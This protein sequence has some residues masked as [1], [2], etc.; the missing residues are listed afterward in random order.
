[1][2]VPIA[3][4]TGT[5][6]GRVQPEPDPVSRADEGRN[7]LGCQTYIA[8]SPS[9]ISEFASSLISLSMIREGSP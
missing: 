6:T 5:G 2:P 9:S 8:S 1:V 3:R 4:E 7:G